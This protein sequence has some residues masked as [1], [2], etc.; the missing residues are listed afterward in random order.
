[1]IN[2]TITVILA[3]K[4]Y[5]F[6]LR[7]GCRKGNCFCFPILDADTILLKD[8]AGTTFFS[9]F[10]DDSD[11]E[12]PPQALSGEP[13]LLV[14]LG[15]IELGS[16]SLTSAF[17][18]GK[19][20]A[21]RIFDDKSEEGK[22]PY[23]YIR[24]SSKALVGGKLAN[25]SEE[26]LS[27]DLEF[28]NQQASA[29]LMLG[30]PALIRNED[31]VS[32]T[33]DLL[34]VRM[35]PDLEATVDVL[36]K[37]H[38]N[39]LLESPEIILSN[40]VAEICED[41]SFSKKVEE[42]MVQKAGNLKLMSVRERLGT[43]DIRYQ[44][45]SRRFLLDQCVLKKS[46]TGSNTSVVVNFPRDPDDL[47]R[48]KFN[49]LREIH[50]TL[51]GFDLSTNTMRLPGFAQNN[52]AI[53]VIPIGPEVKVVGL[54]ELVGVEGGWANFS[55]PGNRDPYSALESALNGQITLPDEVMFRFLAVD[56]DCSRPAFRVVHTLK[57]LGL[58]QDDSKSVLE[59]LKGV[60]LDDADSDAS[61]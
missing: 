20:E 47:Q 60:D 25:V 33:M 5:L 23:L 26:D 51:S 8:L 44:G 4:E 9:F 49:Q 16:L 2:S 37:C 1:M 35:T 11:D 54:V 30:V 59:G 6:D 52:S 18:G 12:S 7:N 27:D 24:P 53:I 38:E 58:W 13:R 36:L 21:K 3:G 57:A 39:D 43:I 28:F 56:F 32:F 15:K 46:S 10:D 55:F 61:S 31:E 34:I 19:V 50:M 42:Y 17:E 29:R 22:Y 45:G 41:E 48:I 40:L 14:A